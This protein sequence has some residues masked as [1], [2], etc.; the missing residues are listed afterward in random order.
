GRFGLEQ[1]VRGHE[2]FTSTNLR[3]PFYTRSVNY[4]SSG[5]LVRSFGE[6]LGLKVDISLGRIRAHEGHIVERREE[7]AAV[8]SIEVKEALQFEISEIGRA[9]CRER[10]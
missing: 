1:I 3:P 4:S 7:D 5:Q 2:L 8:Q 10:V 9:S 6:N